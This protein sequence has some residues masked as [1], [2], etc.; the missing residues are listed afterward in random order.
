MKQRAEA[1]ETQGGAME[2]P[3]VQRLPKASDLS[4]AEEMVDG[5]KAPRWKSCAG[6]LAPQNALAT[7]RL[8]PRPFLA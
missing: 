6:Q 2:V 8:S 3:E 7:G 1:V 4:L 5:A